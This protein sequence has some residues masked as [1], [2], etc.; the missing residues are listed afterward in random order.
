MMKKLFLCFSFCFYS[1]FAMEDLS[2]QDYYGDVCKAVKE[3]NWKDVL[4]YSNVMNDIFPGNTFSNDLYYYQGMAYFNIKEYEKSNAFLSKYLNEKMNPKNFE[5]SFNLKFKIAEEFRKGAKKG[6][7]Q[8]KKSP[9]ILDAREDSIKIY[10]E[11]INS[12]PQSELASKSLF[13]KSLVN[14]SLAEY[15]LAI[16]DSQNLIKTFPNH[17]L[18]VNAFLQ[19]QKAYLNLSEQNMQDFE[20][21]DLAEMNLEAFKQKFPLLKESIQE[22]EIIFAQMQEIYAEKLFEI[23][24]FFEKIKKHTSAALYYKKIIKSFESTE[25]AKIAEKKL[26]KMIQKKI[27]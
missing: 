5:E 26:N 20:L 14:F 6:I 13:A 2:I 7:F 9:K 25:T 19:I 1:L 16:E 8:D 21:L 12:M 10:E 17:A 27:I 18:V 15:N 3:E 23:G 4:Y 11:I 22:A 24:S